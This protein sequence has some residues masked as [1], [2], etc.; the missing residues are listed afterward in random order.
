MLERQRSHQNLVQS[1]RELVSVGLLSR[2]SSND[3]L[4]TTVLL[5]RSRFTWWVHGKG[6]FDDRGVKVRGEGKRGRGGIMECLNP[7]PIMVT[8]RILLA[9]PFGFVCVGVVGRVAGGERDC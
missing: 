1:T 9:Q 6:R 5:P 4:T 2:L 3:K 8:H 7:T